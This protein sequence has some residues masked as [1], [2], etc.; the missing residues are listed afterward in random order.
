MI[1]INLEPKNNSKITIY[2]L[3]GKEIYSNSHDLV[4][5]EN[6]IGLNQ[7]LNNGMY[8]V[9]ITSNVNESLVFKLLRVE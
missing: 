4:K 5:G 7:I 2:N 9:K 6:Q 1:I 8:L 3:Q